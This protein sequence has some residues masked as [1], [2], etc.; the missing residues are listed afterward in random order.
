MSL[1]RRAMAVFTSNPLAPRKSLVDWGNN[2]SA[3]AGTKTEEGDYYIQAINS[4]GLGT[5]S[6][7]INR[8]YPH[9]IAKNRKVIW[10]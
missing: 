1:I 3:E 2:L 10:S 9:Q 5:E 8:N 7:E 4:R 6:P